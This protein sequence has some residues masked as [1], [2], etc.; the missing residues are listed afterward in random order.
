[1]KRLWQPKVYR[2]ASGQARVRLRGKDYYLGRYGSKEAEERLQA[3]IEQENRRRTNQPVSWPSIN[4]ALLHW[5]AHHPA[6]YHYYTTVACRCL[7]A[8]WGHRPTNEFDVAALEQMQQALL[9][10]NWD[11]EKRHGPNRQVNHI[12]RAVCHVWRWLERHKLAPPGSWQ[13]LLLLDRARI[14]KPPRRRYSHDEVLQVAESLPLRSVSRWILLLQLWTAMRTSEAR[15]LRWDAL[16][17]TGAVWLYSPAQHKTLHLGYQRVIPLGPNAQRVLHESQQYL[18]ADPHYVFVSSR[19]R[20]PI[21]LCGYWRKVQQ[22]AR[23]IGLPPA[24]PGGPPMRPYEAR[25]A[26]KQRLT[27]LLGLDAARAVLGHR[28]VSMTQHYGL[29][30]DLQIA[31]QAALLGC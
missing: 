1:M 18:P 30:Q 7:V 9:R 31:Q 21:S 5:S 13:Q 23:Q 15:L 10:G 6:P 12:I 26:A 8:L 11:P 2:H 28:S 17:R 4:V 19:T 24:W 25:H 27:R 22:A 16:D 29:L 14:R 20:R 3:L